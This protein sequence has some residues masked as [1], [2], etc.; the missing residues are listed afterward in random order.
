MS[1][2][3]SNR[4]RPSWSS[5][6]KNSTNNSPRGSFSKSV[7]LLRSMR[8]L[9]FTR[10]PLQPVD[11]TA[12]GDDNEAAIE[13]DTDE[14]EPRPVPLRRAITS[15]STKSSKKSIKEKKIEASLK[16]FIGAIDQGTTSSRFIIFDE[17]GSPVAKHQVELSRIHQQPGYHEQDPEEIYGTVEKCM[18]QAMKA[19]V[20]KGYEASNVLTVGM[21]SQRETTLVWDWETGKPLYNTIAWPDTRHASLVREFK[22]KEGAEYVQ[23]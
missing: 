13:E 2:S 9:L 1:F 12:I 5:S 11:E 17:T 10:D 7:A 8:D 16:R 22:N 19:L 4:P 6:R 20:S 15:G 3:M 14:D 23:E 18:N 21:T